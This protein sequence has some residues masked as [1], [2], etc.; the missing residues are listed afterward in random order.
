[1]QEHIVLHIVGMDE[2]VGEVVQRLV[3]I[4]MEHEHKVRQWEWG[5]V[6]EIIQR[7]VQR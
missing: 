1:M 5:I 7:R 6:C 2:V 3:C 4:R